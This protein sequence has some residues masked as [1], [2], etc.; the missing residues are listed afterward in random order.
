MS[1]LKQRRDARDGGLKTL[2]T[3][4]RPV[5][6]AIDLGASKVACFI[7]KPDGIN[8]GERT[9][10]VA[11]VGYVQSRGVR[12][13]AIVSMEEAA[14]AIGQAVERAEAMAGVS[15]GAVTLTTA[16]GHLASRRV[17]VSTRNVSHSSSSVFSPETRGRPSRP[18]TLRLTR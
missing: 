14:H 8:R 7:M 9:V 16:G 18:M 6:A 11:G 10:S 3:G 13:G 1:S 5:T 2:T 12:G 17:T 15:V 4:G